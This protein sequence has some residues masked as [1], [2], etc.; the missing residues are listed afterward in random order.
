MAE[1]SLQLGFVCNGKEL[2][3]WDSVQLCQG[4]NCPVMERCRHIKIG[5]CHAQVE[6]LSRLATTVMGTYKYLDDVQLYKLGQQI[7][8]LYAILFRLKVEEMG[9]GEVIYETEK[10]TRLVHPIFKE[11]RETLKAIHMMWRDLEITPA[12]FDPNRIPL[13]ENGEVDGS[14]DRGDPTYYKRISDELPKKRGIIR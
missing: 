5:R 1:Q 11:I 2:F 9:I 12:C 13:D 10:G 6:Y 7:I 3:A 14:L 4:D 8:P